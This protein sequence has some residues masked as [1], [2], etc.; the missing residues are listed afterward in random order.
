MFLIYFLV[1][2]LDKTAL[3]H[4]AASPS[5]A[6]PMCSMG[7]HTAG[8]DISVEMAPIKRMKKGWQAEI[9]PNKGN[10]SLLS[11]TSFSVTLVTYF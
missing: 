1:H 5:A 4:P 10:A 11:H 6:A 8:A 7:N 2:Q 9:I 3:H